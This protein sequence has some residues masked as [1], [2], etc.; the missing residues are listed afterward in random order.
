MARGTFSVKE[1]KWHG[2]C[3][4]SLTILA[5]SN[6]YYNFN[7]TFLSHYIMTNIQRRGKNSQS[8]DS[9]FITKINKN[10]EEGIY[11][12]RN[13]QFI[14]AL[15]IIYLDIWLVPD[16]LQRYRFKHDITTNTFSRH[17][18]PIHNHFPNI[19]LFFLLHA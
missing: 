1:K 13:I 3:I 18:L 12:R 5:T 16:F 2:H 11:Y 8:P 17:I 4:I 6:Y 7:A 14:F 15:F 10:S 19:K 9:V